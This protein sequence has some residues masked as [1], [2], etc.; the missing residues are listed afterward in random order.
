LQELDTP[1]KNQGKQVLQRLDES[2]IEELIRLLALVRGDE[3]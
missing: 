3:P 1:V 2:E